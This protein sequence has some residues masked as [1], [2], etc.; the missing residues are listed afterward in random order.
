MIKEI[1]EMA[2]TCSQ[3]EIQKAIKKGYIQKDMEDQVSKILHQAFNSFLHTPTQQLKTIAEQ[4]RADTVVQSIQ[5]FFGLNSKQR[6]ALDT[7]KCDYQL[8]KDLEKKDES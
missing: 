8:Q 4:P 2:R 7:Y 1:R 3:N 5:L 6:K